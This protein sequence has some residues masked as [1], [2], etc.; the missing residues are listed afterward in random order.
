VSGYTKGM[1]DSVS[2][3]PVDPAN[4][5]SIAANAS[6]VD[7]VKALGP[8]KEVIVTLTPSSTPSGL[9]WARGQGPPG[10]LPPGLPISVQFLVGSH[11]PI[12]NVI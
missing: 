1:V 8:V 4:A 6:F 10:K 3:Y 5:G 11:H 2:Q 12:S 7:Q 9:A